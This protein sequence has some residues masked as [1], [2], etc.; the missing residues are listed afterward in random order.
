MPYLCNNSQV[1]QLSVQ[2]QRNLRRIFLK[3]NLKR[4]MLANKVITLLAVEVY[5]LFK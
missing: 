1:S 4:K 5:N 2:Y 3:S